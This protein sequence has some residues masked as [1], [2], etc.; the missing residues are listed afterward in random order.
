MPTVKLKATGWLRETL[1]IGSSDS[2]EM[3]AISVPE[4]ETLPG[5]VC[6]FAAEHGA[7][8]RAISEEEE[9]GFGRD[10]LVILNGRIVNPYDRCEG[11]LKE[12]DE[13]LFLPMFAG[14]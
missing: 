14:G 7:F 4:G 13:V 5:L 12:G 6:H 8:W 3:I 11:T 2:K 10:V 9:Q 1:K